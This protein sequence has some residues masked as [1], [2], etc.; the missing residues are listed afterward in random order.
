M[1]NGRVQAAFATCGECGARRR[2]A[3]KTVWRQRT[4]VRRKQTDKG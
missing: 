1:T 3:M 2:N 4:R